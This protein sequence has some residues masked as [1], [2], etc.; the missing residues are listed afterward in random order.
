MV[1]L[2]LAAGFPVCSSI[3]SSQ[4]SFHYPVR[5]GKTWNTTR[6]PILDNI[7]CFEKIGDR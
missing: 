2:S 5:H 6:I 4:V 7:E 3:G 1:E